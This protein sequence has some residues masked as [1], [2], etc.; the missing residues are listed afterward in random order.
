MSDLPIGELTAAVVEWAVANGAAD[1]GN[2]PGLWRGETDEWKVEA[3]GHE[4]DIDGLSFGNIRLTHKALL[5]VAILT[6]FGGVIGGGY[7]ED[8][9]IDHFVSA[10]SAP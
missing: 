9:L 1:I 5:A 10:R 2:V 4:E 6:P 3:N 7:P 8:K